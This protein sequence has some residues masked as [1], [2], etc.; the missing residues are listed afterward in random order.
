MGPLT[1]SA[2]FRLRVLSILDDRD[3]AQ[4]TL[5][6]ANSESWISN[7]LRG[8]RGL[9]LNDAEEIAAALQV[10]IAELLRR[11]DDQL[12]ELDNAEVRVVDAFRQLAAHEQDAVVTLL[13]LRQR[14]A[15]HASGRQI[16]TERRH[17]QP[18]SPSRAY[19]SAPPARPSSLPPTVKRHAAKFVEDL[20]ELEPHPAGEQASKTGPD[21]ADVPAGHRRGRGPHTKT[22]G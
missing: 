4:K 14:P 12:Y 19:G 3:I 9:A 10:P 1:A 21:R 7:K 11:P 8:T 2:R 20:P 5:R 6:G 17:R 16:A 22:G 13:T 18:T 15:A